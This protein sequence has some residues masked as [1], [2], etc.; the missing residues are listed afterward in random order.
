MNLLFN[1]KGLVE[2][3]SRYSSGKTKTGNRGWVKKGTR[4]KKSSPKL[5]LS[6]VKAH[7]RKSLAFPVK[8]KAKQRKAA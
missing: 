8:K 3:P 2:K 5:K 6:Q 7:W 1:R 4:P